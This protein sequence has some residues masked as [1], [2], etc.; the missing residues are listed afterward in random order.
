VASPAQRVVWANVVAADHATTARVSTRKQHNNTALRHN[1]TGSVVLAT[2]V[3]TDIIVRTRTRVCCLR[4]TLW[5]LVAASRRRQDSSRRWKHS[6]PSHRRHDSSRRWKHSAASHLCRGAPADPRLLAMLPVD[7]LLDC[8]PAGHRV[9][10]RLAG[11]LQCAG[12]LVDLRGHAGLSHLALWPA[13]R[14][15]DHLAIGRELPA[16]P[17]WPIDH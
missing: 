12:P 5:M 16:Y 1:Y 14:P 8:L 9:V 13:E 4:A 10:G 6:A 7:H 11:D 2:T 15:A 3:T 17:R